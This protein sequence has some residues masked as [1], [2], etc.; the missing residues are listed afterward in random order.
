MHF[1]EKKGSPPPAPPSPP[2]LPEPNLWIRPG[3]DD[4]ADGSAEFRPFN[5]THENFKCH[6]KVPLCCCPPAG[7]RAVSEMRALLWKLR[8]GQSTV[9]FTLDIIAVAESSI[10]SVS[11]PLVAAAL[12]EEL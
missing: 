1:E 9:D 12:T 11:P 8:K 2:S 5:F 6:L 3:S 4:A 7:L 10:A